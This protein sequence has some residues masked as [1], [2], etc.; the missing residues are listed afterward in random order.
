[1]IS[2]LESLCI[3]TLGPLGIFFILGPIGAI[4][5]FVIL[6]FYVHK[7]SNEEESE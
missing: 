3:L 4:V 5:A 1:M 2:N 6:A 7:K